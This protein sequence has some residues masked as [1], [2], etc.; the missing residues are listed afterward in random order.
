MS[1]DELKDYFVIFIS[2]KN[3]VDTLILKSNIGTNVEDAETASFL[4]FRH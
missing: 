3:Q 2:K 1:L 4:C